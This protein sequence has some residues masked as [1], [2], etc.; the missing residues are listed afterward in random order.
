MCGEAEVEVANFG[1]VGY[2]G[3]D[4]RFGTADEWVMEDQRIVGNVVFHDK[5]LIA[6]CIYLRKIGLR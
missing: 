3:W 1:T 2:A 5:D 6:D 4:Q